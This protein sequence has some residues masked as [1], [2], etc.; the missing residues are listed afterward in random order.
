MNKSRTIKRIGAI[1]I[2]QVRLALVT[3]RFGHDLG[4]KLALSR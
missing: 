1:A 3:K 4:P 2:P